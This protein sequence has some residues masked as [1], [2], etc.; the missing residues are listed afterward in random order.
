MR[1]SNYGVDES[2][3]DNLTVRH[4]TLGPDTILEVNGR[5]RNGFNGSLSSSLRR[6]RADKR[7]EEATF[8]STDKIRM[9]GSVRFEI[10]HDSDILFS[11]IL[12]LIDDETKDSLKNWRISNLEV[13]ASAV[14][15]LMGNRRMDSHS[16]API[17]DVYVAGCFDG[18]PVVLAKTLQ[19]DI[20]PNYHHRSRINRPVELRNDK[21]SDLFQV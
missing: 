6:D 2:T 16:A 4:H 14:R 7:T 12:E 3:P 11:G 5:S 19:I 13:M 15:F 18:S 8:V 1:I 20:M 21:Y 17:V 10:Y 9:T